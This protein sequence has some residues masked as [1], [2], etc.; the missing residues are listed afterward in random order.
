MLSALMVM[1]VVLMFTAC[2]SSDTGGADENVGPT[3]TTTPAEETETAGVVLA[4]SDLPRTTPAAS[5]DDVLSAAS[6]MQQFGID[7]YGVLAQGA[8]DGNLVFS[9]ASIV[10]ALAMTYVGA[11]GTTAEEM[12]STLH[13]AL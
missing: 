12:A 10:T 9:P 1:G 11:A 5:Q 6:S 8:G 2:G 7:L 4:M 13:F 3:S